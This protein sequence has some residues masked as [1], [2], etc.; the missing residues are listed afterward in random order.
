MTAE[1][2]DN[3]HFAL[4]TGSLGLAAGASGFVADADHEQDAAILSRVPGGA[5]LLVA[6]L[7]SFAAGTAGIWQ[8]AHLGLMILGPTQPV[9]IAVLLRSPKAERL[10]RLAAATAG[11][12]FAGFVAGMPWTLAAG[13]AAAGGLQAIL[14]ATCILGILNGRNLD[15]E[16]TIPC[17][18]VLMC[19]GILA[20]MVGSALATAYVSLIGQADL[21]VIWRQ[22]GVADAVGVLVCLPG[23][24]TLQLDRQHFAG[25]RGAA[26]LAVAVVAFGIFNLKTFVLPNLLL[27][28]LVYVSF[29]DFGTAMLCL[30]L[31]AAAIALATVTG[32]SPFGTAAAGPIPGLLDAQ[33][34]LLTTV[35]IVLPLALVLEERAR[36]G[37]VSDAALDRAVREGAEKSRFITT[38][39]HEIRT[40]MN[41]IIGFTDLLGAT[42]L[43]AEQS[44]YVRKTQGAAA[45]LL[46]MVNDLLDL[47]KAEAGR[48]PIRCCSFG[49]RALCEDVLDV[50]RATPDAKNIALQV[51]LDPVLP[52]RVQGDP[53]RLQQVLLNLLANALAHTYEG[54][55]QLEV[56]P[57]AGLANHIRFQ[58]RDTGIGIAPDRL[59]ELFR[60]FAQLNDPQ[61]R[62]GGTGLGLAIC[63]EIVEQLP[64]GTIGVQSKVGQGSL[65]WFILC[66]PGASG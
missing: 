42:D 29:V 11:L 14:A 47:S 4:R 53:T 28:V 8:I 13:M 1:V 65:F 58:V 61:A 2:L 31:T 46:K 56:A 20:P 48:M 24:L 16:R 41:G 37:R 30:P 43:S 62:G 51:I 36:L 52:D 63:K 25:R 5:A 34:F 66:L 15:I 32:T 17:A 10:G 44:D 3:A 9:L 26:L 38:L 21:A 57:V 39:S 7:L 60:P 49:L 54:S 55:V 23:L 50:L 19:G 6:V 64:G 40:P 22:V 12:L 59:P 35:V 33:I 45:S 27:P 18:I